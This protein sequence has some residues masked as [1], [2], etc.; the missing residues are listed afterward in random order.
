MKYHLFFIIP[1][2]ILK[3]F[4][5][6]KSGTEVK[7]LV[8]VHKVINLVLISMLT[9]NRETQEAVKKLMQWINDV[10]IFVEQI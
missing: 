9:K 10:T 5:D 8:F 4:D 6:G 3:V 2:S 1:F 7:L